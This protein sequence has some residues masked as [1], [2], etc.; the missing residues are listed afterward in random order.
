MVI[1]GSAL[2]KNTPPTCP[3]CTGECCGECHDDE[4][5]YKERQDAS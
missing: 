4:T 3:A 5:G 2:T 1:T